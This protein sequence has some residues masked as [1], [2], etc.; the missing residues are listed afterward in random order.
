MDAEVSMLQSL[1]NALNC[2]E[3]VPVTPFKISASEELTAAPLAS[4]IARLES[5][6][7]VY[8][9]PPPYR[10]ARKTLWN[11]VVPSYLGGC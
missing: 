10:S 11:R 3:I 1:A 6:G 9:A 4:R 2:L 8:A 7:L 5:S